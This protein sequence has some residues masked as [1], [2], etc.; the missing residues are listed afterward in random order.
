MSSLVTE[1]FV[2]ILARALRQT[3]QT[4]T[5]WQKLQRAIAESRGKTL[6]VPLPI[7]L[8]SA[9]STE[10]LNPSGDESTAEGKGKLEDISTTGPAAT[11]TATKRKY[12][13]H[14]K[15]SMAW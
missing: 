13:R 2:C 6:D 3:E 11:G 9:T 15:V 14:P 8:Q 4:L 1:G 12:R 7:A 5:W 10:G